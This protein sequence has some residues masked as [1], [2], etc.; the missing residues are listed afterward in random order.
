MIKLMGHL[1]QFASFSNQGELLCTQGLAY[2]LK[3][4]ETKKVFALFLEHVLGLTVQGN[5][6]WRSEH[7][8]SDGTRPDLE[9]C[10]DNG[11]TVIKI[12]AKL[13]AQFGKDQLKS[14][15]NDLLRQNMPSGLVVLVPES[16]RKEA[17]DHVSSQFSFQGETSWQVQTVS[18]AV[19][20]WEDI[21]QQF[22]GVNSQSFGEDLAQLH[23]L[24]RVLNGDDMEPLTTNEDV[25][26]WREKDAWWERL[27]DL[28]TRQLMSPTEKTLPMNVERSDVPYQRRYMC[29]N[30]NGVETCYSLGLRDP[31]QNHQTPIWL[32]FHKATGLFSKISHQ[33][34]HSS[35]ESILVR[36]GKHIWF[37][38]EVPQNAERDAM[39]ESLVTQV[40]LI[41]STA[42][43]LEK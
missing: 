21:F 32:R 31:F 28:T 23:S 13:D 36:S 25:L 4:S 15:L 40:N 16:R 5:L 10:L 39:I 38:I 41:V 37:P 1:A 14:Y 30:I 35:L 7:R 18:V 20:S 24:Y 27:V 26:L 29:K 43:Q 8:Q 6:T 22:K 42:Y 34:S 2:L 17:S 3:D 12:E 19:I 33:L 9:A 11:V